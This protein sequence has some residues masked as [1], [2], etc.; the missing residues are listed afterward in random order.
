MQR[1]WDTTLQGQPRAQQLMHTVDAPESC[2]MSTGAGLQSANRWLNCFQYCTK[3]L[4][5]FGNVMVVL[6][7]A[8]VL[9][10]WSAV[11]LATYGPAAVGITR[12]GAVKAAGAWVVCAVYT[13]MVGQLHTSPGSVHQHLYT[14]HLGSGIVS[15]STVQIASLSQNQ[16]Q[17]GYSVLTC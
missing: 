14:G 3:A 15:R 9:L 1:C 4:R 17:H 5:I 7:V 11:V 13:L 12:V 16:R 2:R 6:V 8:L 10:S